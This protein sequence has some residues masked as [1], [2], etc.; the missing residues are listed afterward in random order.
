MHELQKGKRG[1]LQR[2]L[3]LHYDKVRQVE[4]LMANLLGKEIALG[5]EGEGEQ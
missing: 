5:E 4:L 1:V 2:C 3:I